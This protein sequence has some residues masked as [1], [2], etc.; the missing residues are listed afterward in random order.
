LNI[1]TQT[2]TLRAKIRA[3][4]KRDGFGFYPRLL[5]EMAT[6]QVAN[7]L[8]S[9]ANL[10]RLFPESGIPVVQTLVP[11]ETNEAGL[12][13][14]SGNFGLAEFPLHSDL[15]HWALPPRYFMLR[16]IV[17]SNDVFTHV[18]S[19][20]S[21][22]DRIGTL[23]LRR[24]VFTVRKQKRGYSCLVRALSTCDGLDVIRWDPLFLRPLNVSAE[25]VTLAITSSNWN[26]KVQRIL[27]Q[28][29]GDTLLVDNWQILHGRAAVSDKSVVRR[30]ERIYLAEVCD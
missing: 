1:E 24:A 5:A 4:L 10:S 12:N 3:D 25:Q 28:N 23:P 16:C 18:L 20:A 2:S 17:G 8:G 15:A 14:Y 6:S 26:S 29:P 30:I 7:I 11:R 9:L 13:Q 21:I 22:V 27:L 19:W